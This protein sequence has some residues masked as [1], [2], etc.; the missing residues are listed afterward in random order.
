MMV[1]DHLHG[2]CL[3]ALPPPLEKGNFT[4][5]DWYW[6]EKCAKILSKL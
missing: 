6:I 1:F 5:L 4:V 3:H 2:I